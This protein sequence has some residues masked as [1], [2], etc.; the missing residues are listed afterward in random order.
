M[1]NNQNQS[2]TPSTS[3]TQPAPSAPSATPAPGSSGPTR[4]KGGLII[5]AVVLLALALIFALWYFLMRPQ[6]SPEVQTQAPTST[7]VIGTDATFEPLEYVDENNKL[8]G[9]DI[10]LANKLGEELGAKVTFK[11][12]PWDDIFKA[13]EDKEVDMIIS[14]VTITDERKKLYDFSESY[15][16]AGQII[17]TQKDN[18]TITSAESL[19]GKRIA[20]QEQTT[21][22]T[23]ALKYTSSELVIRYPDFIQAVKALV[24]GKADAILSELSGA[25]KIITDNPTLKIASE[26]ITDEYYGVVFRKGDT[27]RQKINKALSTLKANNTLTDLKEKWL[28]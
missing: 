27:N 24:D 11:N 3:P 13:L 14:S 12:I 10:D 26:P 17:M 19:K 6:P 4:R 9:Y 1:E 21:N 8:A 18:T 25:K 22:E 20:V 5:G 23:E 16:N 2:P 15:L 7:L 28:E